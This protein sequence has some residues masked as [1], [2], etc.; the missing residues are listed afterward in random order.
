[1]LRCPP[2]ASGQAPL[3]SVILVTYRNEATIQACLASL[4]QHAT[5][6]LEAVVVDNSPDQATWARLQACRVH[7]PAEV[8][9]LRPDRNLGFGAGCNLGVL[10][11]RGEFLLFLNPDTILSTNILQTFLD[12]WRSH[13]R[14]GLLGPQVCDAQGRTERTCRN[15]PT[16]G[17]MLLDAT[18]LDRVF[19][20][21][22]LLH[23]AHDHPRQVPQLIG[24]CLFT[25]R[26]RFQTMAGF[27]E[28][29]F[30]Y[31]EEVDLCKRMAEAGLEIW[32]LPQ[33]RIVHAAGTSCE[34]ESSAAAM[35]AQLRNSRMCY[36]KKHFGPGAVAVVAGIN[37]LEALGKA[38]ILAGCHMITKQRRQL[39]K[40]RGFWRV[41]TCL[42]F[43]R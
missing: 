2:E 35:V 12:W 34:S 13:P 39:E 21:Y 7:W 23:F 16:V 31:Y 9:L 4:F 29:F 38:A 22:R 43:W 41:A 6:P 40:A 33:A 37:V 20:V 18:G 17:G 30:V 24:A 32:F 8:T 25:S 10:H 19:G 26:H 5:V 15:L 3:V 36:F 11:A 1:M 14:A 27:D 42:G 28:R